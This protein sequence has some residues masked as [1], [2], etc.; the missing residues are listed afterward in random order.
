MVDVYIEVAAPEKQDVGGGWRYFWAKTVT[1]FDASIH[2]MQCL[3]GD[4]IEGISPKL[5][6]KGGKVGKRFKSGT[7]IYLCGVSYPYIWERNFHMPVRVKAGARTRARTYTG[8][9]VTVVGAERVKFDDT[10]AVKHFEKKGP[11]FLTCRNF[12]FA[13]QEFAH[14]GFS[15]EVVDGEEPTWKAKGR[16]LP[17][18]K[19]V[20]EHLL[21]AH[22]HARKRGWR[23]WVIRFDHEIKTRGLTALP[24]E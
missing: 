19:M 11:R 17:V 1:G 20:D 23:A 12:Q 24:R 8:A 13:A 4:R 6:S 2:C 7:L 16:Q 10:A 9:V 15:C 14:K 22:R 18:S 5:L 21:N 3:I